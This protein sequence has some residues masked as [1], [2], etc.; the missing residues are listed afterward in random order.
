MRV[1]SICGFLL[2]A[3]IP[4]VLMGTLGCATAPERTQIAPAAVFEA[5]EES[6]T[7]LAT[8]ENAPAGLSM[9]GN[10]GLVQA[11]KEGPAKAGDFAELRQEMARLREEIARLREGLEEMANVA[12]AR[13]EEENRLLRRELEGLRAAERASLAGFGVAPPQGPSQQEPGVPVPG[14]TLLEQI[15]ESPQLRPFSQ[16]EGPPEVPTLSAVALTSIGPVRYAVVKEW[17]RSPEQ[18]AELGPEVSSLKGMVCAVDPGLDEDALVELG[19]SLRTQF[20]NY[21]NI[22]IE[23]FDD[24]AAARSYVEQ[25]ALPGVRRRFAIS[26]HHASNRDVLVLFREGL[27]IEVPHTPEEPAE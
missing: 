7:F 15:H 23:V 6:G 27:P 4:A 26:K 11:G 18:A 12:V 19:R 9:Q 10:R 25:N 21:D 13:L 1:R 17:G 14:R 5:A 24:V 8:G 20:G 16:T 3:G 2:G 22:N